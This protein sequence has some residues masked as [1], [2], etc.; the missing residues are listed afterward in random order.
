[1]LEL[2][3]AMALIVR[4]L[5]LLGLATACSA[6]M[7][8]HAATEKIDSTVASI[9]EM[10]QKKNTKLSGTDSSL[11]V[12]LVD[13]I[14]SLVQV[15]GSLSAAQQS[16]I[17]DLSTK[18][19]E[20]EIPAVLDDFQE[21]QDLLNF[22]A[23]A[24]GDCDTDLERATSGVTSMGTSSSQLYD[25]YAAC[26]SEKQSILDEKYNAS[27]DFTIW[28]NSQLVPDDVVPSTT[29]G[30]AVEE[31]LLERLI[32]HT[33]FNHTYS[34]YVVNET[35]VDVEAKLS[36]AN[37]SGELSTYEYAYCGWVMQIGEVS[38]AYANCR[39]ETTVLYDSTLART[40]IS[41]AARITELIELYQVKC[42]LEALAQ[43]DAGLNGELAACANNVT[44]AT[45]QIILAL[46]TLEV[47]NAAMVAAL[48]TPSANDVTCSD[49]P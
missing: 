1:V 36:I 26:E 23:N 6:A 28:M 43:N 47:Y 29:Y 14:V 16:V 13:I 22:H 9:A 11:T 3:D 18:V 34:E 38:S 15:T 41:E 12:G 10:L 30:D 2:T 42:Q 19:M 44:T 5:M 33:A 4:V 25:E 24:L 8:K 40:Q 37:C 27:V 48:G 32:F 20:E 35:K 7:T 17:A 46:P 49:L 21:D 39:N 31:W 45:S